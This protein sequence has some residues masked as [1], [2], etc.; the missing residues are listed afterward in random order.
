MF[1]PKPTGAPGMEPRSCVIVNK[2]A[3]GITSTFML[4]PL[5]QAEVTVANMN[6]S[7]ISP[8]YKT[9]VSSQFKQFPMMATYRQ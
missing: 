6:I 1:I 7:V 2:V 9:L 5:P 4:W 3:T 8:E